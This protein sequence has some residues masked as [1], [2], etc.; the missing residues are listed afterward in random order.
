M[1]GGGSIQSAGFSWSLYKNILHHASGY[2]IS[3]WAVKV[4]GQCARVF[5][6]FSYWKTILR[7]LQE[8]PDVSNEN[9]RSL[10]VCHVLA[11]LA[12]HSNSGIAAET[13]V[14]IKQSLSNIC[15]RTGLDLIWG[16][17]M[18]SWQQLLLPSRLKVL[19][20]STLSCLESSDVIVSGGVINARLGAAQCEGFAAV[21]FWYVYAEM[22]V[23]KSQMILAWFQLPLLCC[24]CSFACLSLCL[25]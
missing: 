9:G 11:L 6:L 8:F 2:S 1:W 4:E 16:T 20:G 24:T 12:L 14:M 13:Q 22:E 17:F 10:P 15:C 25:F 7:L 23:T 21:P 3:D 18:I 5:A 19:P